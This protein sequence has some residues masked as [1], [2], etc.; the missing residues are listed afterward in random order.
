MSYTSDC[1]SNITCSMLRNFKLYLGRERESNTQ[2]LFNVY[3]Q[4]YI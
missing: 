2:T 3:E 1:I 4:K